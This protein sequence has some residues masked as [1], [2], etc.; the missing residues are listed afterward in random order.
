M[1]RAIAAVE[2]G[3][4]ADAATMG[5]HWIYDDKKIESLVKDSTC[6]EFF[7]PPSCPYYQYE[8]GA[9]SP[10]ADEIFP[11]LTSVSARGDFKPEAFADVSYQYAS[12]YKGRLNGVMKEFVKK[13]DAGEKYPNLATE[14]DDGHGVIKTPVLLAKYIS[15]DLD[16]YLKAVLDA[17]RVHQKHQLAEEAAVAAAVILWKVAN[18]ASIHEAIKTAQEDAHVSA[19]LRDIIGAVVRLAESK[20]APSAKAAMATFG[21]SCPLP[22][23]FQGALYVLLTASNYAEGVRA[24]IVAGGDNCSR[25]IFIGACFA[26]QNPDSIPTEWTLKTTLHAKVKELLQGVVS[27]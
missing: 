17:T 15:R 1:E 14:S 24:N 13:V 27:A 5:L 4:V 12:T 8:S 7:T 26:A 2:G 9:F 11:L 25:G 21:K 3:F 23:S 10:Y 16:S 18:G 6:P 19:S 20:E 22:G